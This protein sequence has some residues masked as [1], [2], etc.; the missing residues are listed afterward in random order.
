MA[1]STRPIRFL[2]ISSLLRPSG[3]PLE[4]DGLWALRFG[5]GANGGDADQLCFTAG[6]DDEEHGLLGQIR[7]QHR[8]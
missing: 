7:A 5:N 6:P 2:G 4:V 8:P 1:G 3:A